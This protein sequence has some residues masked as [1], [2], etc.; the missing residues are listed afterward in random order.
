M[1]LFAKGYVRDLEVAQDLVQD[2]FVHLLDKDSEGIIN[3]KA[4]L[5]TATKNKCLDHLKT[6]SIRSEHH[7][8]I[9][10]QSSELFYENAMEKVELETYLMKLID[11]LPTKCQDIFSKSRFEGMSNEA[12]SGELGISKRTVETQISNALKKIRDGLEDFKN[13]MWTFF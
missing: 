11:D 8:T 5:L 9:Q 10:Q 4:Y 2:V 12:I 3:P 6:T 7:E 1:V 13:L